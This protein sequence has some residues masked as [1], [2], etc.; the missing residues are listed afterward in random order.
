MESGTFWV[1][2]LTYD[3]LNPHS[4]Q[5]QIDRLRLSICMKF[6][7][8]LRKYTTQSLICQAMESESLSQ[9]LIASID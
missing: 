4:Y 8:Q 1:R 2:I 9:V 7:A 5:I 6:L 3:I